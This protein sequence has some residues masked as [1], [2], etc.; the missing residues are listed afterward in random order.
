MIL[1]FFLFIYFHSSSFIYF[2]FLFFIL[3]KKNGICKKRSYRYKEF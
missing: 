3:N 2:P 1:S